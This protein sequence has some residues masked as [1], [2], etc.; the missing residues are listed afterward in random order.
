[1]SSEVRYEATVVA[2]LVVLLAWNALAAFG[3]GV[4]VFA[5][6]VTVGVW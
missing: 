2:V 4:L 6:G 3:L 5:V 1:M